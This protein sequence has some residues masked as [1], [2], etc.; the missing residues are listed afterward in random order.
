MPESQ[1][2]GY[3]AWLV[4]ARD[5]RFAQLATQ[6]SSSGS[7]AQKPSSSSKRKHE[8]VD[9]EGAEITESLAKTKRKKVKKPKA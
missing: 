3:P 7:Q 2:C 1:P 8:A 4:D 5:P 9:E 6:D